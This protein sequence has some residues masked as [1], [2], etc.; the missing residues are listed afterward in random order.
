MLGTYALSAGYYDAYY[1]QAQKVRTLV[2]EDYAKAFETYDVLVSPTSPTTAFKIGEK[3]DDPLAM[4]LSDAFTIPANFAGVPSISVPAGLDREGLPIGLQFTAKVLD[5][6]TL[7]RVAHAFEQD[8][9]FS[10]RPALLASL[11]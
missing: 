2:I 3:A 7:L 10:D 6:P 4:Y 8:L 9:G 5:E 11:A 1:G